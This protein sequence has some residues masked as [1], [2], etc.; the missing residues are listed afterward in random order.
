M[1]HEDMMDSK[2]LAI[3]NDRGSFWNLL[4]KYYEAKRRYY[5]EGKSKLTDLEFDALEHTMMV[6]HGER[7]VDDGWK[8]VGYDAERHIEIKRMVKIVNKEFRDA[9]NGVV[10]S[11]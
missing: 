11:L 9:W 7:F 4:N 10:R 3:R 6:L 2:D 8:C 1:T 5:S